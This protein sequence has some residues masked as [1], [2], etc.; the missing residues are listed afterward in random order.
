[1]VS[2]SDKDWRR[3]PSSWQQDEIYQSHYS[4]LELDKSEITNNEFSPPYELFTYCLPGSYYNY[5]LLEM[6]NSLRASMLSI[7]Q[8]LQATTSSR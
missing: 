1:M 7:L 2:E 8:P 3:E 6:G 4:S 5:L